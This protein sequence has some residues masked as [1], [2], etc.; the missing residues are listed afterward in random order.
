MLFV[1]KVLLKKSLFL[2]FENWDAFNN[3]YLQI[4]RLR[5][6]R[7]LVIFT[8]ALAHSH[9][10][11]YSPKP[12]AA[13][14]FFVIKS[15]PRCRTLHIYTHIYTHI[16]KRHFAIIFMQYLRKSQ[17]IAYFDK[18]PALLWNLARSDLHS[19]VITHRHTHVCARKS[20]W[21]WKLAIRRWFFDFFIFIIINLKETG[22]CPNDG[23][24]I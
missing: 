17:E 9:K 14:R 18:W 23:K 22:C 4:H 12:T 7:Q 19:A 20:K 15:F 3:I 5:P 21:W 11:R 1:R 6:S 8:R 24:S 2:W 16:S 13:A 10:K